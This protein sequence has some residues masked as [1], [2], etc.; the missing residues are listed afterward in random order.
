MAIRVSRHPGQGGSW[1]QGSAW[2]QPANA[3]LA[4]QLDDP[5][6]PSA[7]RLAIASANLAM[8]D[9]S[10]RRAGRGGAEASKRP[11]GSL[12]QS[13]VRGLGTSPAPGT[14]DCFKFGCTWVSFRLEAVS[15]RLWATCRAARVAYIVVGQMLLSRAGGGVVTSGLLVGGDPWSLEW[16]ERRERLGVAKLVTQMARRALAG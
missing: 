12:C 10:T 15:W 11:T 7:T 1:L 16:L 8:R 4:I 2:T 9:D 5:S 14:G 3:W 13:S 6:Q